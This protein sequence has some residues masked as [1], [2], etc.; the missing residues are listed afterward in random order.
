MNFLTFNNQKK[1]ISSAV[2]Q[3]GQRIEN[4]FEIS[5]DL[6]ISESVFVQEMYH[7][8]YQQDLKNKFQSYKNTWEEQTLFSS[9]M[10]EITSNSAYLSIIALG[11]DVIPLIIA[12]L[13]NEEN[14]WFSALEA[15]T[16]VNPIKKEHKGIF[17]LMKSDWLEWA[18]KNMP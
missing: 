14:H 13:R 1:Q 12:N 8:F 10:T 2:S 11:K 18:D 9:N 17:N 7:L 6:F 16:G 15:L 4:N 3:E 5:R